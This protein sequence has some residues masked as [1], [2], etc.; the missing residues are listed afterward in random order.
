MILTKEVK[1]RIV[2][3]NIKYYHNLNYKC[4]IGDII[5]IDVKDLKKT[6]KIKV[7]V[8]CNY[9]GNELNIQYRNAKKIDYCC[10]FCNGK[11]EKTNL[12]KY[13]V[14]TTLLTTEVKEKSK[15]TKLEKYNN[16]NF[17]NR[18]QAKKTCQKK[19]NVDNVFQ[20]ESVKE[21][22]KQTLLEH[23]DVEHQMYSE[24]IKSKLKKTILERYGVEY[25]SKTQSFKKKIHKTNLDKYGKTHITKNKDFRNKY[26]I[27]NDKN[28]VKYLNNG[29]SLFKCSEC[30]KFYEISSVF[31][32]NRILH[33]VE[34]CIY[35]N[36]INSHI[37]GKEK[38]L[39]EYIKTIYDG[40]IIQSDRK[41][42]EGKE[43]DI[44]LPDLKL[45]FEFNGTYWH[46]MKPEGYHFSKSRKALEKGVRLYHIWEELWDKDEK[47]IKK[48]IFN[49]ICSIKKSVQ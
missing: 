18:E 43:I 31:Y 17:N 44:Y 19:Y 40:E 27:T 7:L 47:N 21:K 20:L 42:L 46:S 29:V 24:E 26:K 34:T 1:V 41:I 30:N 4:K 35:C 38:K 39:L 45:G 3:R 49:K 11:I 8:K 48:G 15:K 36:P 9:C 33:D 13:G 10:N 16:V 28:Y 12:K 14:K 37:S 32:N 22:S 25:Y 23:F 5:E 2:G 6:S